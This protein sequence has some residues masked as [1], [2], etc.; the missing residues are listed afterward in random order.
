MSR[1]RRSSHYRTNS[2]GTTFPVREHD[3]ARDEWDVTAPRTPSPAVAFSAAAHSDTGI[4]YPN[5]RCPF[6]QQRVYF[7]KAS[8]GGRVFFDTLWPEW[9][10]HPCTISETVD[11]LDATPGAEED[12]ARSAG[13]LAIAAYVRPD[14]LILAVF[15]QDG[16][17][18]YLSGEIDLSRRYL[19]HA[20]LTMDRSNRTGVLSLLAEDMTPIDVSVGI[21][22]EPQPLTDQT[23]TKL[24]TGMRKGLIQAAKRIVGL[25]KSFLQT[26]SAYGT[27]VAGIVRD[28]RVIVIPIPIDH[29]WWNSSEEFKAIEKYMMTSAERI[30]DLLD[31]NSTLR[32]SRLMQSQVVYV[33]DDPFGYVASSEMDGLLFGSGR[34]ISTYEFSSSRSLSARKLQNF[35]WTTIPDREPIEIAE[36]VATIEDLTN[37]EFHFCDYQW[38]KNVV[39]RWRQIEKFFHTV[40]LGEIFGLAHGELRNAGW[41]IYQ[42]AEHFGAYF[43]VVYH[44]VEDSAAENDCWVIARVLLSLSNVREGVCF[45]I[46]PDD[47]QVEAHNKL[48]WVRTVSDA[49][50]LVLR[51]KEPSLS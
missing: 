32:T 21:A 2:S 42:S 6:C 10:K 44:P 51:L 47:T 18:Q 43:D 46:D 35:R 17:A 30:S 24:S 28:A 5:A 50:R 8:N 40:G 13:D 38:P 45:L 26:K 12:A 4:I 36:K 14:E 25:S 33:F 39:G 22:N 37:W 31:K 15:D 48:L 16:P 27:F 41:A 34:E 20:W 3:V 23:R 9:D 49:A 7:F 1:F 29:R 19:P 11:L